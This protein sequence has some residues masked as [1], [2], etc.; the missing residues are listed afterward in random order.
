MNREAHR[1]T[2]SLAERGRQLTSMQTGAVME[3]SVPG[4]RA[5]VR[6]EIAVQKP[7][8]LRV[9][10]MSPFGVALIMTA[11]GGEADIFD[12]EHNRFMRGAAS[13]ATLD[14][15]VRIPMAP[16]DAVALLMGLAPGDF[17]LNQPP[18][19]VSDEGAMIVAAYG[20]AGAE[21]RQLGFSD[22]NLAMV[23]EIGADGRI[24]FEVR[25]RDYRDIGGLMFPYVVEASFPPAQSRITLRYNRPLINGNL[26]ASRFVLTPE[27][28]ATIMNLGGAVTDISNAQG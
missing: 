6:E 10:A 26:P 18:L 23:R 9:D 7:D 28:G 1:L 16:A 2:A 8:S 24:R 20:S 12:A 17:A 13:A 11:R 19:T 3:Y 25:Y 15:Y 21:L 22:G 14:R 5:K 27:K 4:D